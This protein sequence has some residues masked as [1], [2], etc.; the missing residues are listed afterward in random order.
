LRPTLTAWLGSFAP[1]ATPRAI[2][3]RLNAEFR[4]ALEHPDVSKILSA[5]TAASAFGTRSGPHE[6]HLVDTTVRSSSFIALDP[7]T[8]FTDHEPYPRKNVAWIHLVP[9]SSMPGGTARPGAKPPG[10]GRSRVWDG[11]RPHSHRRP[12]L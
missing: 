2:V 11:L 5:Q 9:P 6:L 4:K 10:D 12:E 8:V 3:E 7:N 1:S